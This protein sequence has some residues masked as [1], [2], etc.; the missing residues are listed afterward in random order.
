[1]EMEVVGDRGLRL[2]VEA[3]EGETF[4]LSWEV[5]VGVLVRGDPFPTGGPSTRTL[6]EEPPDSPF[7]T[8]IRAGSH[9]DPYYVAAM[10]GFPPDPPTV[11]RHWALCTHEALV[12]V[13]S[14]YPPTVLRLA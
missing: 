12:E 13:A 8:F 6:V 10:Q 5:T 7:L 3:A 9:A 1:M 14:L 11:L 4:E 2:V